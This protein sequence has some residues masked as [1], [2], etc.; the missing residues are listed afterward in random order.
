MLYDTWSC[1]L[2]LIDQNVHQFLIHQIII[3]FDKNALIITGNADNENFPC[4]FAIY[5]SCLFAGAN[6]QFQKMGIEQ[7]NVD[8]IKLKTKFFAV[9]LEREKNGFVVD[10]VK[11]SK[12]LVWWWKHG[13]DNQ[14]WKK[15]KIDNPNHF[16]LQSGADSGGSWYIQVNNGI[17]AFSKLS[18][19]NKDSASKFCLNSNQFLCYVGNDGEAVELNIMQN[20]NGKAKVKKNFIR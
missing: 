7:G 9:Y 15:I 16:L 8:R 17:N 11:N 1:P 19:S 12:T 6:V 2:W 5:H 4:R 14:T 13:K 3:P 20:I 10:L 18:V